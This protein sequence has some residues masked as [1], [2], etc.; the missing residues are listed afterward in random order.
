MADTANTYGLKLA[1]FIDKRE[2]ALVGREHGEETLKLLKERKIILKSLEE[3]YEHIII[4]IPEKIVT[5][6]KSFFLGLFETRI[7]ELGEERFKQLYDFQTTEYIRKKIDKH[8][9]AALLTSTQ[10]EILDDNAK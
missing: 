4:I 6:N 3:N 7:Q 10:K 1:D 2:T 5:I 9:S 8:I